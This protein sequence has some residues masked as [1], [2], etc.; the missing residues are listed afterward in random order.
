M[1]PPRFTWLRL[2]GLTVFVAL[3]ISVGIC[4][5]DQSGEAERRATLPAKVKRLIFLGDSVT[6]SGGYVELVEAYFITR[7]PARTVEFINVGLPSE[8]VS[9]LSEEGHA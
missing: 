6:Y 2:R 5:G 3:S 8:T 1:S 4:L 7:Y 9:G